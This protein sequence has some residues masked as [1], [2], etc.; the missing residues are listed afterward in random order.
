MTTLKTTELYTLSG[1]TVWYVSYKAV[2]KRRWG[3]HFLATRQ[4]ES[5]NSDYSVLAKMWRGRNSHCSWAYKLVHFGTANNSFQESCRYV[6]CGPTIPLLGKESRTH[7]QRHFT[8]MFIV[9]IVGME[10][11]RAVF[12]LSTAHGKIG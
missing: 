9:T 3:Y 1:H 7:A 12:R 5:K 6:Y 11:Q 2:L 8:S 4:P 10:S